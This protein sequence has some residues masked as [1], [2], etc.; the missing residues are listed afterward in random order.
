MIL[1]QNKVKFNLT[2]VH[3]AP[4]TVGS[5]DV[6]TWENPTKIIGAVSLTLDPSGKEEPFHADG[7]IFYMNISNNGYTG[8]LEIATVPEHF[9]TRILGEK[10]DANGALV[11]KND[12]NPIEFALMFQFDGDVHNTRH[13]FYRC[14]ANRPQIAGTT[15][16]DGR[17]IKTGTLSLT[18]MAL[19]DGT[20]KAK[21]TPQI[22]SEVYDNWF[23][24]V[25]VGM[26]AEE[27]ADDAANGGTHR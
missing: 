13:V 6:P 4:L 23:K 16:T 8:S 21:T 27:E 20:I 12:T 19:E 25:Y 9:L 11:E 7:G 1:S 15:N 3:Y 2:N 14:T 24:S 17:E 22:D 10:K 26:G 5:N 18:C